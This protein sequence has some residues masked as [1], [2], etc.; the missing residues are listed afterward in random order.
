MSTAPATSRIVLASSSS[1]RRALLERLGIAFEQLAPGIDET[2]RA[3]E[4]PA[5]VARRL[6]IEKARAVAARRPHAIVVA[7]DQVAEL[8]GA[9]VGKPATVEENVAML[10]RA[11]ARVMVFHTGL[12]V[13]DAR[14]GRE[15]VE[16]VPTTVRFRTIS[17]DRARRYVAREPALDCAGG[18][19]CEGLG[20]ALF[21]ALEGD[22]PTALVG[23]PLIRLS[24]VLERFGVDVLDTRCRP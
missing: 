23:L 10:V 20:I 7:S 22:D 17:R 8:D 16:T 21:S 3:G 18:F 15:H 13:V 14:D 4:R 11:S 5:A 12:A 6:T 2:P 24:A 9:P 19:R 1:Y